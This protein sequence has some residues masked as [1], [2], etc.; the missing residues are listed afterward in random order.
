MERN[1]FRYSAL[2]TAVAAL[3]ISGISS[4]TYAVTPHL[5]DL[6]IGGNYWTITAYDDSSPTHT[7]W[8]TQGICFA[9]AGIVGTHQRYT[10]FSISFPD[11]N[12]RATQEGD[13]ITMHGDYAADVGHDGMHWDI[14]TD[15]NAPLNEG[16]GHWFEWREDGG[17][18][19]TIGFANAKLVRQGPCPVA[20]QAEAAASMQFV[21]DENP[22]GAVVEQMPTLK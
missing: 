17:F 10:W 9:Y 2:R 20:A 5:P 22:M 4:A 21:E 6:V 7:Q 16:A 3:F 15:T 14:V 12:G 13:Q 19:R 8:A 11:W 18:G 1:T